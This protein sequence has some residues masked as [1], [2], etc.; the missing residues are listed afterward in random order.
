M[1]KIIAR[2]FIFADDL[3]LAIQYGYNGLSEKFAVAA[4]NADLFKLERYYLS[5]RLRAN[6]EKTEVTT[7][8]PSFI[9]WET[10]KV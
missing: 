10:R 6:P 2:K 8:H 3:A 4:L 9:L 1:H 7:F 5:K